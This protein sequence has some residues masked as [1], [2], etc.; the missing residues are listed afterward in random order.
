[1]GSSLYSGAHRAR[2]RRRRKAMQRNPIRR[3]WELLNLL[4]CRPRL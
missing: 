2:P 4:R 3:G 1:M